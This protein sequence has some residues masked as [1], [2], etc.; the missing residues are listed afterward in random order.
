MALELRH[1]D[2]VY[3]AGGPYERQALTDISLS[4]EDGT[5]LCLIGQTGSGKSTLLQIL[6][7]LL[8]PTGGQVFCG[9]RDIH[10]KEFSMRRLREMIGMVFQYPEYQLFESTV[11]KDAA[12]GPKNLGASE[13]EALQRAKEGLRLANLPEEYW[14]ISP[15]ELSGGEKRRAAIAGV[16]AMDPKVLVMDEPTAGLDPQGRRELFAMLTRLHESGMTIVLVSHSM[17][18]VAEYAERVAVLQEGRLLFNGTPKAV[19]SHKE[20]L[21]AI[22][23]ALPE[24]EYL[25]R[26][27][28]ELGVPVDPC[29]T[30]F[31][32]VK[33]AVLAALGRKK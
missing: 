1:V 17:E 4:V 7:G 29:L 5:F 32:E 21:E 31:S 11:L 27:L 20:E 28:A 13:A 25:A 9:G 33:E 26:E 22:H 12:F 16:L 18:D 6:G 15:F 24:A 14:E 30:R 10:G 23:L 8:L 19:F 2:Y 3:D